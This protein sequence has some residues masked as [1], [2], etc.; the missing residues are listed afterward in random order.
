MLKEALVSPGKD[1]V[2]LVGIKTYHTLIPSFNHFLENVKRNTSAKTTNARPPMSAIS[3]AAQEKLVQCTDKNVLF[4]SK[5]MMVDGG[6]AV[7]GGSIGINGDIG[8]L[9]LLAVTGYMMTGIG[10]LFVH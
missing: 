8:A 6:M 3:Q 4:P 2:T 1:W 10:A 5:M 9:P 7:F